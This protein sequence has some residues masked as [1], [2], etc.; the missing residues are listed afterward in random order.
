M[1]YTLLGPQGNPYGTGVLA[2]EMENDQ[3]YR[4]LSNQFTR[5]VSDMLVFPSTISPV[6]LKNR[7]AME[8]GGWSAI[9]M[10]GSPDRREY[11]GEKL[12][13]I[14]RFYT[15]EALPMVGATGGEQPGKIKDG[16]AWSG[17]YQN[18]KPLTIQVSPL[19]TT[20]YY[21]TIVFDEGDT[22]PIP[23]YGPIL[24]AGA[25]NL[26][27]MDVVTRAYLWPL[28]ATGG[29]LGYAW[30]SPAEIKP[31]DL[32]NVCAYNNLLNLPLDIPDSTIFNGAAYAQPFVE[33]GGGA[34]AA[35]LEAALA[36]YF[37][38]LPEGY[39]RT[40]SHYSAQYNRYVLLHGWGG[41]WSYQAID[42][43]QEKNGDIRILYG[44][45]GQEDDEPRPYGTLTVRITPDNR[46]TY[47]SNVLVDEQQLKEIVE[48]VAFN[49]SVDWSSPKEIRLDSLA[50]Q[51]LVTE[52]LPKGITATDA[53]PA[54]VPAK[55]Y[56]D[57]MARYFGLDPQHLRTASYYNAAG[58]SY[59][60]YGGIGGGLVWELMAF[61][62]LDSANTQ[63]KY[64]LYGMDDQPAAVCT[65]TVAI[66]GDRYT[67]L[68]NM[69][70]DY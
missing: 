9:G 19:D 65:L 61:N 26:Y 13:S 10:E 23:R 24:E 46:T 55:D 1:T 32:V 11:D 58:N 34:E 43:Q 17:S 4:Y 53:T 5:T 60:I 67:Y 68:S 39:L 2:M 45:L 3:Q 63:I 51:Y 36:P 35:A 44:T 50:T 59:E 18:G 42:A 56:E 6:V 66:D 28:I 16:W 12:D 40:S 49:L 54:V 21:I 57:Y 52:L 31:D 62:N 41:G 48:R 37:A 14:V 69:R 30:A 22:T 15:E 25:V 33:K 27:D 20:G 29:P 38:G 7:M 70:V 8:S 47:I 64:L